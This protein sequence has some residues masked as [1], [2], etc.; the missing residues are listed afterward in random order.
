MKPVDAALP[1][2]QQIVADPAKDG[3][4]S[5]V[6]TGRLDGSQHVAPYRPAPGTGVHPDVVIT[7]AGDTYDLYAFG[8]TVSGQIHTLFRVLLTRLSR[9]AARN[10]ANA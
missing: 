10:P 9:H 8:E 5:Y 6:V 2:T 7:Y 1:A 4:A 3:T